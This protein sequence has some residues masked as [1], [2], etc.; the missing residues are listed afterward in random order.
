MLR[1]R[2][3]VLQNVPIAIIMLC[4]SSVWSVYAEDKPLIHEADLVKAVQNPVANLIS[5]PFQNNTDFGIG[6]TDQT[7][8]TLNIQPVVPIKLGGDWLLVT[9]TIIPLLRQPGTFANSGDVTP[10]TFNSGSILGLGDISTTLFLSPAHA[11]KIIWG[12]GP[13][14][15]VPTATNHTLGTE[16]WNAG[17]AALVMIQPQPWTLGV[18][19]N[20][21]WSY[22]GSSGRGHVNQMLLQYFVSYTLPNAWFLTSAPV[23]TANW[24]TNSGDRWTLPLGGGFGRVF[25]IGGQPINASAQ[26]YYNIIKPDTVPTSDWQIRLVVSFLFPT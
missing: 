17:P 3:P 22:A 13:I 18:L 26:A 15:S 12:V 19:V 1:Y 14:L 24:Q 20:N 21:L 2:E 10:G 5:L 4:L 11:E 16:K 25:K 8:N 23:I 9:R 6:P 7:R